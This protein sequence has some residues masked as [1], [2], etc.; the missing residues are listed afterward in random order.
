MKWSEKS[1]LNLVERKRRL[2]ARTRYSTVGVR[3]QTLR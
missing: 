2:V 1:G 3:Q